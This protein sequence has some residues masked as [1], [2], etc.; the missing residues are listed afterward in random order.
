ME[1]NKNNK[2][3]KFQL[4]LIMHIP[5]RETPGFWLFLPGPSEEKRAGEMCTARS[6]NIWVGLTSAI[7]KPS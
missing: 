6:Q 5:H 1:W 7:L 2:Y 4:H 3:T